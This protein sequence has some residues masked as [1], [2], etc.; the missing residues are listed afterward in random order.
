MPTL[1]LVPPPEV[2]RRWP[3]FR[4]LLDRAIQHARGELVV[5]DLLAGVLAG[6]MGVFALE[7]GN[8]LQ[9]VSAFEFIRYPRRS[10]MNLI[11]TGGCNGVAYAKNFALVDQVARAMGASAVCC[12]CRPAVA[13]HIEHLLPGAKQAYIVMEREVSP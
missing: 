5:D 2:E 13:R 4:V 8:E 3:E 7:E 9:L 12:Y 10:V 1:R 6:K 11:A